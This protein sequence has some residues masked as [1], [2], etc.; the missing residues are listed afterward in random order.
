MNKIILILI[1]LIPCIAWGATYKGTYIDSGNI[2]ASPQIYYVYKDGS[3]WT[4]GNVAFSNAST[5]TYGNL[6]GK[7]NVTL[8]NVTTTGDY[9]VNVE[10]SGGT[11]HRLE[12][13]HESKISDLPNYW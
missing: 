2:Y 3:P 13:R 5:A 1:L 9:F 12:V 7:I 8:S 4:L 6:P 11:W 10:D